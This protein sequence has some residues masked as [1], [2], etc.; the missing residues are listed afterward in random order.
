MFDWRLSG[1][2]GSLGAPAELRRRT[3]EHVRK[4]RGRPVLRKGEIYLVTDV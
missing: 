2:S 1:G 4:W 3:K